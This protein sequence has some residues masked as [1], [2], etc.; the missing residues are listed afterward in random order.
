MKTGQENDSLRYPVNFTAPLQAWR[1]SYPA[2]STPETDSAG[3]N[4]PDGSRLKRLQRN[5]NRLRLCL[6]P[7]FYEPTELGMQP[8]HLYPR[9]SRF[10]PKEQSSNY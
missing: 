10:A 7:P 1:G 8:G 2:E 4:L 9:R 6:D 5:Y 3:K